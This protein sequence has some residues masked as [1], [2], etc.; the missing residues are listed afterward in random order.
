[1]EGR[2]DFWKRRSRFWLAGDL[3]GDLDGGLTAVTAVG[4]APL[5]PFAS[6]IWSAAAAMSLGDQKN[7]PGTATPACLQEVCP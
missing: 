2:L 3:L 6:Q 1:M 7:P 4:T 5:D